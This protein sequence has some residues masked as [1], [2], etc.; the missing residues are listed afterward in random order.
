[1]KKIREWIILLIFAFLFLPFVLAW[2]LIILCVLWIQGKAS[3]QDFI[4]SPHRP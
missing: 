4:G 3:P 2:S 1:M